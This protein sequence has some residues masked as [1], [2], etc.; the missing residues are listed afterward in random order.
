MGKKFVSDH[1]IQPEDI[2]VFRHVDDA[3][4]LVQI[5]DVSGYEKKNTVTVKNCESHNLNKLGIYGTGAA[6]FGQTV[7]GNP[8]K[9]ASGDANNVPRRIT[10]SIGLK[11]AITENCAEACIPNGRRHSTVKQEFPAHPKINVKQEPRLPKSYWNFSENKVGSSAKDPIILDSE[12]EFDSQA[13]SSYSHDE[14]S[15]EVSYHFS[16][17]VLQGKV[18]PVEDKTA[19][20]VKKGKPKFAQVMKKSAV[21]HSIWLCL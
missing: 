8:F 10:R 14:D 20:S 21:T 13:L 5:F 12:E 11:V 9:D 19:N 1:W 18:H 4:F 16:S 15:D 2:V 3:H 6:T 7:K 17:E